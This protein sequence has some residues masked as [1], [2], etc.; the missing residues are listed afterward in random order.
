MY[1]PRLRRFC[2]KILDIVLPPACVACG[3]EVASNGAFCSA[4]FVMARPASG[5]SCRKCA[6]VFSSASIGGANMV[7]VSCEARPPVWSQARAAFEYD[8]WSRKLILPL[9]YADRTENARVLAKFMITAGH[10]ILQDAD[11]IVPV[12]LHRRKLWSRRYNQ[13]ALL[14]RLIA[15][16]S[17]NAFV[18]DALQRTRSTQPLARLS[19]KERLEQ[20]EGV[21]C[22]R[23]RSAPYMRGRNI[24]LVDDVLTTG[25]T[26][27]YCAKAL[28]EI[29]ASSVNILVAARAGNADEDDHSFLKE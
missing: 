19:P 14:G 7:C 3:A 28:L 4:C 22:A 20:V 9:K 26:A 17:G 25:V 21:F 1:L 11:I 12:P 8:E 5:P 6:A 23:S 13:A 16:K 24:V 15:K 2:G 29:G 18:A 27:T 10:D